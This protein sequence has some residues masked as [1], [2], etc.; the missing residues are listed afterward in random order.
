MQKNTFVACS[1]GILLA[2]L[3]NMTRELLF[4]GNDVTAKVWEK[5]LDQGG[6]MCYTGKAFNISLDKPE[7]TQVGTDE[8]IASMNTLVGPAL[9]HNS[10]VPYNARIHWTMEEVRGNNS[11]LKFEDI[12]ELAEL[13]KAG[14]AAQ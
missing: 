13:I 12:L 5:M 11:K 3:R 4:S 10:V 8:F 2:A 6:Y 1:N 7:G 14:Q 9:K